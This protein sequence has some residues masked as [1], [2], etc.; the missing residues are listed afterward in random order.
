MLSGFRKPDLFWLVL[1][2]G[3]QFRF[4]ILGLTFGPGYVGLPGATRTRSLNAA[5][6]RSLG[7][8]RDTVSTHSENLPG[9]F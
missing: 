5:L 1:V 9:G 8:T 6:P 4:L 2:W 7:T 3:L